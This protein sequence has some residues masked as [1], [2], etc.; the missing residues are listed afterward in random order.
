MVIFVILNMNK[1]ISVIIIYNFLV[2][3][4]SSDTINVLKIIDLKLLNLEIQDIRIK[5]IIFLL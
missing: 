4:Y 1:N 5:I 2:D 3:Q